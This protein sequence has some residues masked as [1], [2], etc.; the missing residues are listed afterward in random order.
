[1][2]GVAADGAVAV[3]AVDVAAVGRESER[4]PLNAPEAS[5]AKSMGVTIIVAEST[6][7]AVF[8]R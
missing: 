4:E 1:M 2:A 6:P 5:V 7:M 3:Q 8:L